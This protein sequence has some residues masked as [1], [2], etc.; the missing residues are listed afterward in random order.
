MGDHVN[1]NKSAGKRKKK[2][3]FLRQIKNKGKKGNYGS[4]KSLSEEE[5]SYYMRVLEQLKHV[6]GEEKGTVSWYSV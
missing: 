4:G 6:E 5:Y 2:N 3:N 1:P